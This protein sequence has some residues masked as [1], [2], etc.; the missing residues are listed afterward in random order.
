VRTWSFWQDLS[1]LKYLYPDWQTLYNNTRYIQTFGATTHLLAES[2][3]HL[4]NLPE[5][6]NPLTL[7][8]DKLILA[9]A[10]KQAR[11]ATKPDYLSDRQFKGLYDENPFY[12]PRP[13][14]LEADTARIPPWRQRTP[15]AN[16]PSPDDS[17]R[18]DTP[19]PA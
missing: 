5:K 18:G 11:V 17:G 7:G 3:A 1:Q 19:D 16:D 12:Q 8:P 15:P 9:E 4:L 2:I 10:G 6:I 14:E 13:K